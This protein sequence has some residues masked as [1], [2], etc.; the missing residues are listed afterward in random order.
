[1]RTFNHSYEASPTFCRVA[2]AACYTNGSTNSTVAH[3][4][5]RAGLPQHVL[6]SSAAVNPPDSARMPKSHRSSRA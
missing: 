5:F 2:P 4:P 3:R 1:M 6:W